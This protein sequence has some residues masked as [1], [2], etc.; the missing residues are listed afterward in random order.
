MLPVG[1]GSGLDAR[2]REVTQK[3][4]ELLGQQ[5]LV[6]N[7]PGAGGIIAMNLVAKA[8]ADGYTL[9]LAGI[10]PVAY[11]SALYRKLPFAPEEFR[12][13]ELV[14][15]RSIFDLRQSW[16]RTPVC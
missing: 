6:E 1:P 7:R 2:A 9:A 11:Y 15:D 10:A 13:G 5:V 16:I 3:L 8:P 14:G 4:S 12:A